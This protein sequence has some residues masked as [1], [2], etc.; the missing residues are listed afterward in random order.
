MSCRL[1]LDNPG[2]YK[3]GDPITGRIILEFSSRTNFRSIICKLR[4]RE[5]TSWTETES[6]Y[7]STSKTTK[8][9]TVHYSGDNKFIYINLPLMHENAL[10]AGRYEYSFSFQLPRAIPNPYEGS[11]GYIRYYL[12]ATVDRSFAFDYEDELSLHVV[13]P[14]DFNE[15]I[16]ELQLNPVS[17]QDEKTICCCCCASGPITMDVVLEKEAFVVGEVAKIKVDIT[18]M[19]NEST[20][21][22][23]LSLKLT[24][25]SKTTSP[26]K[27]YKYDKEYIQRVTDSG[28][29]A[30][31]QR[32]YK[33][34]FPIPRSAVVP[35]F[36][37]CTLF[38]QWSVLK[39]TAVVPGCHT[40]LEVETG[41]KLGHIPLPERPGPPP[42]APVITSPADQPMFNTN[43]TPPPYPTDGERAPPYPTGA[44]QFPT[45]NGT[46]FPTIGMPVPVHRGIPSSSAT[47][48]LEEGA[49]SAP[50]K[51]KLATDDDF[52]MLDGVSN[53]PPPPSYSDSMRQEFSGRAEMPS[54][55]PK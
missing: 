45:P 5:H 40:N 37:N 23:T 26:S 28:V 10:A 19:S 29:G 9:R 25:E 22:L 48:P 8:T 50:P 13:S 46:D 33:I 16:Q 21:E 49:A 42:V 51:A 34:N 6:Y 18:N 14:I 27:H 43:I 4:G 39:V 38:K 24:V 32:I 41:I 54:A 44:P 36:I 55:P 11:Y 30:H 12:K 31:G 1:V 47:A 52:E 17:Y 35:N 20:V 15:I 53:E 2:I 3:P 7:D